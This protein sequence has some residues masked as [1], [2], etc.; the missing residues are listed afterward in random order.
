MGKIPI[1]TNIILE[2]GKMPTS[3]VRKLSRKEVYKKRKIL[4]TKKANITK[5]INKRI[6]DG[7]KK[8]YAVDSVEIFQSTLNRLKNFKPGYG[9]TPY[10]SE[11]KKELV[12]SVYTFFINETHKNGIDVIAKRLQERATEV[13]DALDGIMYASEKE[14]EERSLTVFYE[15]VKGERLTIDEY[16]EID[17]E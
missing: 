3:G 17:Q 11:H 14:E 16:M 2:A 8:G 6:L 1:I 10:M 12:D 4:A 15:I 7:T 9:F 5:E 13:N